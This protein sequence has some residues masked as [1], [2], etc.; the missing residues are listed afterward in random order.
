[1]R[2]EFLK[3]AR[4][5]VEERRILEKTWFLFAVYVNRLLT[6]RIKDV[7]CFVIVSTPKE[8]NSSKCS[9]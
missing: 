8:C 3:F 7:T 2:G 9:L 4:N 6:K 5:E 1:M